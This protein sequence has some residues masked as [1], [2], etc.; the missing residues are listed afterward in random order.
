MNP[1]FIYTRL[2]TD[3]SLTQKLITN[4][5]KTVLHICRVGVLIRKPSMGTSL[6]ETLGI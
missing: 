5:Q 1:N 2:K 4:S 6:K 3:I